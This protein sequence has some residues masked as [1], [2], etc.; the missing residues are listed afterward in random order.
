[1]SQQ[2]PRPYQPPGEHIKVE[3]NLPNY[4][5]KDVLKKGLGFDMSCLTA[6]SDLASFI[7]KQIKYIWTG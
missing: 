3:L 6:K 7:K 2:F 5:T 1:M 4:A